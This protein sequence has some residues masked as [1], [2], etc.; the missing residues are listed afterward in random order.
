MLEFLVFF[1]LQ[2]LGLTKWPILIISD[3]TN[4]LMT[5]IFLNVQPIAPLPQIQ[6]ICFVFCLPCKITNCKWYCLGHFADI[7]GRGNDLPKTFVHTQ[8]TCSYMS[9]NLKRMRGDETI[10]A[11]PC[12]RMTWSFFLILSLSFSSAVSSPNKF[13]FSLLVV[14]W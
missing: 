5:I 8:F 12:K 10:E 2:S 7:Q 14:S 9:K 11:S 4:N 3:L 6:K 13:L 1:F